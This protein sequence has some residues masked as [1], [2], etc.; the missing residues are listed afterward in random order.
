[1]FTGLIEDIGVVKSIG[2][3]GDHFDLV[4]ASTMMVDGVRLG[5]SIAI[6]G[7]CLTVTQFDD[8]TFTVGL[9]P[10]TLK[11]TNLGDLTVGSAVNLERSLLPTTRIGGHFVQG[12]VDTTATITAIRPDRDALWFTLQLDAEWMKYIAPKGYI[13]IDGTS[14]TVV[15]TGDDWFTI[16]LIDYSQGKVILPR[17]K[18][19]D[20]VNIEVDILAKYTER[21]FNRTDQQP[22]SL[23]LL[24]TTGF[25]EKGNK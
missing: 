6:N 15:D 17:K 5:D 1:M 21:L 7:V 4:V 24:R 19:G 18:A 3:H 14:L 16:T 23:D 22:V 12:H 13:S 11:R 9:A 25:A 8:R 2:P 20:H 10:E